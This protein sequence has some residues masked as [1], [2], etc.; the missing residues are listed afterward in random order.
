MYFYG[1]QTQWITPWFI[2][3][4][5]WIMGFVALVTAGLV[6]VLYFEYIDKGSTPF[7]VLARVLYC[8]VVSASANKY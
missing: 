6:H 3:D 7:Y 2:T 5:R 1:K 4:L 8:I